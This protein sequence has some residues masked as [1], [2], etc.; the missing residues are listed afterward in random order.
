MYV[1]Y[2]HVSIYVLQGLKALPRSRIYFS[3][4]FA[5]VYISFVIQFFNCKIRKVEEKKRS[6]LLSLVIV[7]G[8]FKI[9]LL[10]IPDF[11][12]GRALC[13]IYGGHVYLPTDGTQEEIHYEKSANQNKRNKIKPRPCIS[14]GIVHLR[15]TYNANKL[16]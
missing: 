12:K 13:M 16:I 15:V 9:V 5:Q 2:T 6:L 4:Q 10:L 11:Y 1:L 3:I 7:I 14:R 8:K